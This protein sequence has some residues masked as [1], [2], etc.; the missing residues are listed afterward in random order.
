VTG[1]ISAYNALSF[2]ACSKTQSRWRYLLSVLKGMLCFRLS[3]GSCENDGGDYSLGSLVINSMGNLKARGP[4]DKTRVEVAHTRLRLQLAS[5]TYYRRLLVSG[6]S[7]RSGLKVK[8]YMTDD[9]VNQLVSIPH[10]NYGLEHLV[11][12][13]LVRIIEVSKATRLN[14]AGRRYRSKTDLPFPRCRRIECC[15]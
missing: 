3:T 11:R 6:L 1:A 14:G 9:E 4:P 15:R 7:L 5:T 12:K 10:E 2:L 13:F 8:F